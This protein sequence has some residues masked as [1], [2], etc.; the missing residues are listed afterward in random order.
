MNQVAGILGRSYGTIKNWRSELD[1]KYAPPLNEVRL[2]KF[3][4]EA[5]KANPI[6]EKT[7]VATNN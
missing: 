5:R 1:D 6:N 4:L 3:E 2:L 7:P